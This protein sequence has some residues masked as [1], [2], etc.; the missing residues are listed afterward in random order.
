MPGKL[1][2]CQEK[3]PESSELFIVEGDS[4]G[5][6]AKQGRD[7]KNQAILPLR[8]KILNVERARKD[9]ILSSTEI[10]TLITA[11]GAGVGNPDSTESIETNNANGKFNIDKMRYHKIIIMTDADVDGS[12]IRT[13]LLTFFY[14]HMQPMIESGRLYIAQPPLFRTKKGNSVKYLKNEEELE[15]FLIDNGIRDMTYQIFSEDNKKIDE[16]KGENLKKLIKLSKKVKK[17][18]VPLTRRINNINIIEQAAVLGAFK[19]D[20]FK[21]DKIGSEVAKF[22][23]LQLNKQS[24]SFEKKW[25]VNRNNN[26]DLIIVKSD[27]GIKNKFVIDEDFISAPEVET[28]NEYRKKLVNNFALKKGKL[29]NK[30]SSIDVSGPIDLINTVT[31]IGKKGLGINRYK[32]LG[33]MNPEQLWDTTLKKETRLLLSVRIDEASKADSL[34]STLMGDEVEGRRIFIQENSQKVVNLDI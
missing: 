11:I 29:K 34:L 3:N 15:D 20:R 2:D 26:G 28:L 1:A 10:G 6:S 18:I 31:E 22:L 25:E 17:Y 19:K 13:L 5:G 8:G 23:E 4:A 24:N 33:E 27:D 12:H 21:D 7:R 30:D 32:G 14:R 16:L 9:K